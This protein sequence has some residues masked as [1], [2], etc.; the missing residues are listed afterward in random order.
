MDNHEIIKPLMAPDFF[1]CTSPEMDALERAAAD[2]KHGLHYVT[3]PQ[4]PAR[5]HQIAG[6]SHFVRLE[7]ESGEDAAEASAKLEALSGAQ[8]ADATLAFLYISHLLAPPSPLPANATA[9]GWIDFDDV[10]AKIGWNPRSTAERQEMRAR[11]YNFVL[12][13]E[14]AQVIG[15]R[16]VK[17]F[18]KST[19]A[20]I[21]TKIRAALWRIS[22]TQMPGQGTLFPENR[23]PV[24]VEVMIAREWAQ[25]LTQPATAQYL[26]MGELLGNIPGGKAKG[27]WARVIGLSLASFWRR[28]PKAAL[29]GS[30]QPKRRELLERYPPKTG[31]A[32]EVLA[33][34][35]PQDAIVFWC[36][37]L[38]I[39]VECGFLKAEGEA[40]TTP[41]EMRAALPRKGWA[42]VW[43]NTPVLLQPGTAFGE[44]IVQRAAA[45][46]AP[47][48]P[49]KKRGRPRKQTD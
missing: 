13:A 30:I 41:D 1:L 46:P 2:G 8:D 10:I 39:L 27:A 49:Q 34:N 48:K 19:G 20:E 9:V 35:N 26:P 32:A 17:Y 11:L 33:S 45:L 5:V 12:F 24:R 18:D 47:T 25:L 6:A 44:T 15:E 38:Q 16:S 14:R 37:A 21:D 28:Q 42:D 29:D 22:K 3:E 43:L 4:T 7:G 40:I 31:T 36:G 23:V